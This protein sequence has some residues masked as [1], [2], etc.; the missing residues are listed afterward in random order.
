MRT[1]VELCAG[2]AALSMW[3]LG[4][5]RPPIPYMGSKAAWAEDL[6]HW[7]RCDRPDRVVLVE[8]GIWGYWWTW[9]KRPG[10]LADTREA[11]L[12][13]ADWT[14]DRLLA[15][16]P[17]GGPLGWARWLRIS[18]LEF[19]KLPVTWDGQSWRCKRQEPR[20][21]YGVYATRYSAT[22]VAAALDLPSLDHVEV[23]I[24]DAR[25]AAVIPGAAVLLDPPYVGTERTYV[26]SAFPRPDVVAVAQ[27]WA[28][29]GC[30]IAVTEAAPVEIPGWRSRPLRRWRWTQQY[31]TVY[32]PDALPPVLL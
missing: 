13:T 27:R 2:S 10:A 24:G 29:E 22:R 16:G 19:K 5:R 25:E 12:S 31:V 30:R 9:A 23:V 26:D 17:D 21:S 14:W 8:P 3:C 20:Q 11:V 32:P 15:E 4:R 7:L 6:A 1:L 28:A 18:A